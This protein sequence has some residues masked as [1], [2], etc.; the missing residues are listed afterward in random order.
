MTRAVETLARGSAMRAT[1]LIVGMLLA[2]SSASAQQRQLCAPREA[3]LEKLAQEFGEAP[4]ASGIDG[5][6]NLMEILTSPSGTWTLLIVMPAKRACI[7][8][9]GEGWVE[10][11]GVAV[12]GRGA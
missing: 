7:V 6:G 3:L 12:P 8:G 9:S 1:L 11:E 10:Y 4:R 5:G 2:A